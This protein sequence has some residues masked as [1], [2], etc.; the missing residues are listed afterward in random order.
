M[1]GRGQARLLALLVRALGDAR[2]VS[3]AAVPADERWAR[4]GL[5]C[6]RAE[7]LRRPG[8]G[9]ASRA[10]RAELAVRSQGLHAPLPTAGA[11]AR[12][13]ERAA[14]RAR[15]DRARDR[16]GLRRA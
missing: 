9:R 14:R 13:A 15:D 12:L 4:G 11:D 7:P 2:R 1:L 5:R 6:P 10:A 3:V 8:V 16:V